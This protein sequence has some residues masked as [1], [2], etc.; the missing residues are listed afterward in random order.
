M[1]VNS[2]KPVLNGSLFINRSALKYLKYEMFRSSVVGMLVA[3]KDMATLRSIDSALKFPSNL[4][5]TARSKRYLDLE[6]AKVMAVSISLRAEAK[7]L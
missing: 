6:G 5:M 4:L 1:L 3:P 2:G 7:L